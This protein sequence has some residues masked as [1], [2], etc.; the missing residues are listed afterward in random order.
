MPLMGTGA[1][2]V[3]IDKRRG[4]LPVTQVAREGGYQLRWR[5]AT[6]LEFLSGPTFLSYDVSARQLTSNPIALTVPRT[7]PTGTIALTGARIVTL[8]NRQVIER[9]D[10]IVTAGRITCV[11]RC[12]TRGADRVVDVKGK[13]IIPGLVD[14]HAH[15]HR[16]HQGVL[17]QRNWESAIYLAHG[18]TTTLDNSMWS[19]NVFPVAELVEAGAVVGPRMFSTGDPLYSGD[20]ARQNEI[21]S[22][23]AAEDNVKRLAAWGAVMMKQYMQPRR[24]QRQWVSDVARRRGLM[25]TAEGGDLAYNLGMI[26]DGQTGWEHPMSYAPFY[27]D[28]ATFFGQAN[29]VYSPTAVVGG[30][31]PWNDEYFFGEREVWKD[32]K[33]RL[34]MPWRQLIPH[35]RRRMLRPSTDY[36][37]PIM[38]QT[39]ADLIAQGGHGAIGAH[40]Q[41]H[42]LASHWEVWMYA[43]ALG[44][45]GALELASSG[46]AYFLGATED[47]GTIRSGKLADLIVLNANPLEDIRNTTTIQWVMKGGVL[48]DGMTLDEIWPRQRPYGARPWVDEAALRSDARPIDHHDRPR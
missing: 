25:V 23:A 46:G 10:V 11:G 16:D 9:G 36:T 2:P 17:P 33:L 35:S 29:T 19:H 44:A 30:A 24:D 45:H 32:A 40:G 18:V 1:T 22:Y 13:T 28:V 12:V 39:L 20:A 37:Y 4:R 15:H 27:S 3:R 31:G 5:N 38:A 48:Y 21:T 26:M 6:T 7:V 14:V 34:W 47:I 42:G 41:Q 43:T 8:D